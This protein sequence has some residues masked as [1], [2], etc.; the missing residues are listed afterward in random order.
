VSLEHAHKI[1]HDYIESDIESRHTKFGGVLTDAITKVVEKWYSPLMPASLVRSFLHAIIFIV[2]GETFVQK[3][4][5]KRPSVVTVYV[6]YT[7]ATVRRYFMHFMPP[8]RN[9]HRLSD[10]LMNK[11]Y[12]CPAAKADF[13]QVGPP[14]VIGKFS[15]HQ[16]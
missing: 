6:L 8:R 10:I 13:L 16:D 14:K 9:A 1:V 3:L 15:K 11:D 2:G 7:L 4:G 5:L 12:M